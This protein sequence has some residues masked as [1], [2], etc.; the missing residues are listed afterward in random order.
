LS[1]FCPVF[2]LHFRYDCA[3]NTII[4]GKSPMSETKNISDI[5]IFGGFGDLSFRKLIPA[6]YHLM[7]DG[8]ISYSS[9]IFVTTRRPGT[10]EEQLN[11]IKEKARSFMAEGE[12]HEATWERFSENIHVV[13]V[14]IANTES[15]ADLAAAL[16]EEPDRERINYLS[17]DPSFFGPICQ[18]LSEWGLVTDVSRVVLEKPIGRDLAS[19]KVINDE[20]GLYFKESAIFRIDHYLGKDTVQNIIALRFSNMLFMPLWNK[21]YIDHIQITAAETVGLEARHGYY[22]NYG[23]LRDMIQN[24]LLQLLCLIAMEPPYSLEANSI[25]DE[26]VKVLRSLIKMTP[27]EVDVKTVRGRY[28]SD[29]IG[30]EAVKGY[31]E[32]GVDPSSMTETFAAVRVDIG[33]WR[34]KDVP[35]YLRTGKRMSRRY[36]EIVIQFKDIPMHIFGDKGRSISANQLVIKLQPE[37]SIELK[38]MTKIPGLTE[39]MHLREMPLELNIPKNSP[40]TPMAYERL[41]LD[42]IRNNATLFM[43]RDEVEAAWEWADPILNAW[44]EEHKA[45]K[46]YPAGTNGPT[47]SVAMIERDGRSWYED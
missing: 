33:N 16:N 47:A 13:V 39:Q 3:R 42:V 46:N 9:R 35:F 25:R 12:F 37:E 30:T 34:W 6:L 40:R 28:T 20:V 32:E 11:T 5:I 29:A 7:T 43:R 10:R 18:S 15:Y 8:Y 22:E 4:E 26:K 21:Q 24:H 23:A 1:N 31:L 41:L 2:Q 19:S 38:I 44:A 14:D 36:T 27:E 45:P 17:T